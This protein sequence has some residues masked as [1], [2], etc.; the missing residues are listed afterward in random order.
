ML[1]PMPA[2]QWVSI[3]TSH[4][5]VD[6]A[7]ALPLQWS[8]KHHGKHAI[9]AELA[10]FGPAGRRTGNEVGAAPDAR[11]D[12]GRRTAVQRM[13]D[14]MERKQ[15]RNA[16]RT[17]KRHLDA[18]R[19]SSTLA[20]AAGEEHLQGL[21]RGPPGRAQGGKGKR[22]RAQAV[23]EAAAQEAA[24]LPSAKRWQR[25]KELF[26]LHDTHKDGT[27]SN[28]VRLV[29]AR[30]PYKRAYVDARVRALSPRHLPE[31]GQYHNGAGPKGFHDG[32]ICEHNELTRRVCCLTRSL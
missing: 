17:E 9:V 16:W 20:I 15:Q 7:A 23:S 6:G 1:P 29:P 22:A 4:F 28:E 2:R 11:H 3:D 30:M 19:D 5:H 18:M 27:V 26:K 13:R 10:E 21:R 24:V 32:Q 14:L 12:A 31:V 25:L 8:R